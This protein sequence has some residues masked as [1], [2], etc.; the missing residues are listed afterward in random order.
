MRTAAMRGGHCLPRGTRRRCGTACLARHS[1]HW[2]RARC[3]RWTRTLIQPWSSSIRAARSRWDCGSLACAAWHG[4]AWHGPARHGMVWRG[5]A[6]HGVAWRGMAWHGMGRCNCERLR[7]ISPACTQTCRLDTATPL[8][9]RPAAGG[10]PMPHLLPC[11]APPYPG[12]LPLPPQIFAIFAREFGGTDRLRRI[13]ATQVCRR[14][15]VCCSR[16]VCS[17]SCVQQQ[18]WQLGGQRC[19]RLPG[20][21][22]Q[23]VVRRPACLPALVRHQA[24]P[25]PPAAPV[26]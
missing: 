9:M 21:H 24:P 22:T 23:A 26:A 7:A 14:G 16:T 20:V 18:R 3:W 17:S 5:M 4:M 10:G 19:M 11:P 6:W 2:S 13:V 1:T 15:M 8:H 25:R 12:H